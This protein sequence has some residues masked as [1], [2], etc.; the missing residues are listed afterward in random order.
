[1]HRN[2]KVCS[3]TPQE[4]YHYIYQEA[5]NGSYVSYL[6]GKRCKTEDIF[7]CEVSASFQ[8]PSYYGENWAAFDEC[9]HDLEWIGLSKIKRFFIVFDDF[10]QAFL[11]DGD[12]QQ[13]LQMRV[14]EYFS[15]AMIDWEQKNISCELWL[16]N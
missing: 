12:I 10:N 7:L 5:E 13:K 3:F 16:N 15:R 1:M 2:I 4:I 11:E 14:I 6:R 8:F 9:I